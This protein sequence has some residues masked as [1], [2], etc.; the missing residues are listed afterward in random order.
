MHARLTERTGLLSSLD[1]TP[2]SLDRTGTMAAM[3]EYK[4][5]ALTLVTSDVARKAFDLSEEPPKLR[6]RHGMHPWG[7]RAVDGAT[8]WSKPARRSSPW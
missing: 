8:V 4:K 5:S 1:A 7:Q 3:D 2:V 6:E